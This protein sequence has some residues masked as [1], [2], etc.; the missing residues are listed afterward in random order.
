MFFNEDFSQKIFSEWKPN[1]ADIVCFLFQVEI[2]KNC[3]LNCCQG[4]YFGP[5]S[6]DGVAPDQLTIPL[7][8]LPFS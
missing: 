8:K 3:Y 1:M 4:D 7:N 5:C 6:T 2:K